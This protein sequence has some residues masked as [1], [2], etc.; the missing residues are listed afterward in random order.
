MISIGT[1]LRIIDNSGA[2]EAECIR[3]ISPYKATTSSIGHTVL[4]TIKKVKKS[5]K[6][7]EKIIK[8]KL[9]RALVLRAKGYI[10]PNST[11]KTAFLENS[12]ILLTEHEKLV[13]S[14]IVGVVNKHFRYTKYLKL[15]IVSTGVRV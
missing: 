12:A 7:P 13:G 11:I 4:L 2:R 5:R 9:F 3:V 10:T 15:L 14:R 8:G 1:R 6:D